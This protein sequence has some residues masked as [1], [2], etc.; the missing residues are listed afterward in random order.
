MPATE[1]TANIYQRPAELLQHLIRFD[2]TNPPGNEAACIAYIRDLLAAAGIE[3]RTLAR[4]PARPNLLA[5][6][7]GAGDAPPLLLYG[8]VDVVPTT[9]QEWTHPPFA[10]EEA[11]GYIWGRG[12]IDMKGEVAMYL[13]AF[14]RAKIEGSM[15]PGDVLLL[16]LS[17]EEA[18]GEYGA[19]YM[20][21]EHRDLFD[22]V[23]FALGE[24]GGFT[25]YIGAHRFYPIMVAEKQSCIVR[26]TLRGPGGH[27]SLP[28]RGG[29]AARL[30][31]LLTTLD[32]R[33]LPV[34]VTPAAT[35]MITA[36]ASALQPAS[37]MLLRR[38]LTPALTD[39]VLAL[40]GPSG[41]VFDPLLHNTVNATIIS[42]GEKNNVIPSE[43]T[44][45]MDGRILP[46]QTPDDLLRELRALLGPDVELRVAHADTYAAPAPDMA[47]FETLAGILREADPDGLPIPML[48][49]A[50]TDAR[51]FTRIGIQTYGFTPM[52]LPRELNFTALLH[53]ADERIPVAALTFGTDAVFQAL[54]RS[55]ETTMP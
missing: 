18:G 47:L 33:R 49:A 22:G 48:L 41:A 52:S 14:L 15:L 32:R 12:A 27:A 40:L 8:H 45:E 53:A 11:E 26:A 2:T 31:R 1:N 43:I 38:L 25:S 6:L 50:V 21:R 10:A 20:T 30:G 55:D 28:A 19:D 24:L 36:I 13:A 44:V 46:G 54:R 3:S 9:H 35:E 4:D 17:D 42:G 34:H 39:R 51:F 7:P 29:A 5:R 37:S 23:R 16:I